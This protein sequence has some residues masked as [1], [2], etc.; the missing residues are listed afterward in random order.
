MGVQDIWRPLETPGQFDRRAAE[1]HKP[2]VVV[3]KILSSDGIEIE[4]FAPEYCSFASK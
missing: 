3:C 1:K 4:L 2:L